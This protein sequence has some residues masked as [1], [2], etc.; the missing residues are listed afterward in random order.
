MCV[1]ESELVKFLIHNALK[2]ER[3]KSNS[4][5]CVD[6][7]GTGYNLLFGSGKGNLIV[8]QSPIRSVTLITG[9]DSENDKYLMMMF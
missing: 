9:S 2:S 8:V 4:I 7:K 1:C 5:S 3:S 6:R